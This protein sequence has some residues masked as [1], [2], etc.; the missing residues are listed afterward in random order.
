MAL[1]EI[2][3]FDHQLNATDLVADVAT[4]N[5][6][7]VWSIL[8]LTGT[9]LV[10]GAAG[11]GKALA[12]GTGGIFGGVKTTPFAADTAIIGCGIRVP[13]SG[14]AVIGF[15]DSATQDPTLGQMQLSVLFDGATG[16]ISIFR[17]SISGALLHATAGNQ[18]QRGA[19]VYFELKPLIH[20]SAGA[21]D[22]QRKASPYL[23]LSGLNTQAGATSSVDGIFWGGG[24]NG[25]VDNIYI[26][27]TT[28]GA[29]AN[30]FDA[31]QGDPA[32]PGGLTVFTRFPTAD[33]AA[34]DFTP[35]TGTNFSQ[36]QEHAMDSDT[37]YNWDVGTLNDEDLF[38]A[39]ATPVGALP[40]ACKVQ[41]SYREAGTGRLW[42]LV[43]KLRSGSTEF[44]GD[45][46]TLFP[47]YTYQ[48]DIYPE[49][50]DGSVP[51]DQAAVDASQ[52]G[53]EIVSST[54]IVPPPHPPAALT[55]DGTATLSTAVDHSFPS[56]TL[57]LTTIHPGDVIIV[58]V[59]FN[60]EGTGVLGIRDPFPPIVNFVSN[61]GGLTWARRVRASGQ[62]IHGFAFG[63]TFPDMEV[64]WAIAPAPLTAE[65]ITVHIN[66]DLAFIS[67]IACGINGADISA[68]TPWDTNVS[69]PA[70][71]AHLNGPDVDP[72]VTGVST[73]GADTIVLLFYATLVPTGIIFPTPPPGATLVAG[74]G[75]IAA[76][77]GL[78]IT[79][80]V[81]QEVFVVPLVN[82]TFTSTSIDTTPSWFFIAD[83]LVAA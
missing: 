72:S 31:F 22:I 12:L 34:I 38:D 54:I 81:W 79:D 76:G 23:S 3:G 33:G 16:V 78:A 68:I 21:I 71:A 15:W 6:P 80:A 61:T 25:R 49:N 59:I 2:Q 35:L 67:V 29:G 64:W 10:P 52:I 77:A 28:T 66:S 45:P 57:N 11:V 30:P 82:E 1:V 42:S 70:V 13:S 62:I 58:Q 27:D 47:T 69:L 19:Y 14:N 7:W 56:V 73:D 55:I 50:P 37:S 44:Q 51:W 18:F 17:G 48:A 83:A 5:A 53:Y 36:V 65:P 63:D 39:D 43:N 40:L 4:A 9:V 32:F 8:T 24:G 60:A 20:A 74:A 46:V 41:G 26:A 75:N